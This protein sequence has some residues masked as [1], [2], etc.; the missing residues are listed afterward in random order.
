MGLAAMAITSH[1]AGHTMR[2]D[3]WA[4]FTGYS[5][6]AERNPEFVVQLV[7]D[8]E[9]IS[10]TSHEGISNLTGTIQDSVVSGIS[11]GSQKFFPLDGR[12]QIGGITVKL[13][14][15][16]EATP[17]TAYKWGEGRG[18]QFKTASTVG[19][20]ANPFVVSAKFNAY[21]V[22]G[23]TINRSI[24]LSLNSVL[25]IVL[26]I[27]FDYTGSLVV[28]V[29]GM[30][31]PR[32]HR[33]LKIRAGQENNVSLSWDAA[34]TYTVTLNGESRE[35]DYTQPSATNFHLSAT[36]D[37]TNKSLD[38][39]VYDCAFSQSGTPVA[40]WGCH[41]GSG[42]TFLD[43][44]GSNHM[45][46]QDVDG[47]PQ[48]IG[49]GSFDQTS[50]FSN[51]V[52]A[53]LLPVVSPANAG[54]SL[55][56]KQVKIFMG[57]TGNFN[58]FVQVATSYVNGVSVS[59][60]EYSLSCVDV[61]RQL[62][63]TVFERAVT[64]LSASL[65]APSVSP[66]PDIAVTDVT[67]FEMLTHT[68]SFTDQPNQT[69]G[70]FEIEET[71]EIIR[72][73][74]I[75][76]S[77]PKFTGI[78]REVFGTVGA[79]V[80]VDTGEDES[81]WAEC[82]EHVYIEMPAIQIAYA[83]IT[84]KVLGSSPEITFPTNWHM[85]IEASKLKLSEWET[86]GP[87]IYQGDTGGIILRFRYNK[88][89]DGKKFVETE[90]HKLIGTF[91]P[92]N[93]DGTMGLARIN[94]VLSGASYVAG[95][96]KSAVVKAS[97]LK[98]VTS[99]VYN[100]YRIDYGWDGKRFTESLLLVD[101]DSIARNDTVGTKVLKF[102]GLQT[103]RHS[104]TLIYSM[105]N[106][107]QNRYRNPPQTI[108]VSVLPVWDGLEPN[109]I[110]N[111]RL[112]HIHDFASG[113][114]LDRVFEIQSVKT[115]WVNGRVDLNLFASSGKASDPLIVPPATV[116]PDSFYT[117]R[118]TNIATISPA[119]VDGSGNITSDATI[120][121][122][123]AIDAGLGFGIVLGMNQNNAIYYYD[124]DLTVATGVTLFITE[125]VQLRV[126]GTLTVNGTISGI[127]TGKAPTTDGDAGFVGNMRARGGTTKGDDGNGY[128][129]SFTVEDNTIVVGENTA[130][131]DLTLRASAVVV[132]TV[133]GI[134]P[135]MRGGGGCDGGTLTYEDN[136]AGGSTST[137]PGSAGGRGGA[138]LCIISRLT[139]FGIAGKIDLS[140]GDASAPPT[141]YLAAVQPYYSSSVLIY[142]G[143]GAGAAGGQGTLLI[144]TDG[145]NNLPDITNHFTAITGNA[146]EAGWDGV[147]GYSR[148]P[149]YRWPTNWLSS[150]L[151]LPLRGYP[152]EDANLV[153]RSDISAKVMYI[154]EGI[155]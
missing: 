117:S 95:L 24:F 121:G 142:M 55:R 4:T 54:E 41:E 18:G 151:A 2:N 92:I 78:S 106:A 89:T 21:P 126:S 51:L 129:N 64:R 29:T 120:A 88:K 141:A 137:T 86:I 40:A 52:R 138:G 110:V 87:D 143:G 10:F 42:I 101:N 113:D 147:V 69:V 104:Q 127:A 149:Q 66:Q 1:L 132:D 58:D 109:D 35:G 122:A 11:S 12:A 125:N 53:Q 65:V 38:G 118:G 49:W 97:A 7:Y 108:N 60:N 80:T 103:S 50:R 105:I 98:H 15:A 67:G 20:T 133:I 140:G 30:S 124:G 27:G 25:D 44:V 112:D 37:G 75:S 28:F 99:D 62:R 14:D 139:I 155:G 48:P 154:S 34:G 119:I 57:Y 79:A 145:T 13:L 26:N 70:Y 152:T 36:K 74:G 19:S 123:V 130:F 71:G 102:K 63:K 77:P 83:V 85:G 111:L 116:L 131:P 9:T 46:L 135:D 6:Q 153:D 73:T 45:T 94:P 146:T 82:V 96:T 39:Y 47:D 72:Y 23:R 128:G 115:D 81:N 59:N 32:T 8:D 134:P 61:T 100:Q 3:D 90:I 150:S 22:E 68:A 84:G 56:N 148:H 76:A 17:I 31:N 144:L 114:K 136:F 33:S 91:S 43:S 107:L 5:I 16:A 93:P